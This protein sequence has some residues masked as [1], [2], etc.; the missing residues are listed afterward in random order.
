MKIEF[1]ETTDEKLKYAVILAKYKEKYIFVRHRERETWEFPGGHIELGES[2]EVAGARE[3][4]EETGATSFFIQSRGYY[5]VEIGNNKSYG[6]FFVA[7]IY[8][9]VEL[10]DSEIVEIGFF[11][12]LPHS[13]TYPEIIKALF[14]FRI[15]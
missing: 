11:D 10:K 3:L 13:L 1:Y 12:S 6:A 8:D 14:N 4:K 7:E 9:F 15:K 2:P 5:S